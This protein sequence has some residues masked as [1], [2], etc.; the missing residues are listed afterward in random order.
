MVKQFVFSA[1]T[2]LA[3]LPVLGAPPAKEAAPEPLGILCYK[4][5][6]GDNVP[7]KA[8]PFKMIVWR[9]LVEGAVITLDD[10]ELRRRILRIVHSVPLPLP[11]LW[12]AAMAS[13]GEQVDLGAVLPP[14]GEDG[15]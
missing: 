2:L 9:C 13:L 14:Y 15:P 5:F 8:V 6:L 12:L 11:R 4:P 1:M 3:M 7:V 10:R